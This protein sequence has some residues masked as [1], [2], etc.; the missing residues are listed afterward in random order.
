MFVY[1]GLDALQHP[2]G[3]VKA[4]EPVAGPIAERI[5]HL[6]TDTE[7]LV[8]INGAVM[9]G[10]GALLAAGKLRRLASTALILSLLPTTYAGHR[11]WE[12]SDEASRAQQRIHFLKN[13]GLLGGLILAALDTEGQPSWSWRAKGTARRAQRAASDRLSGEATRVAPAQAKRRLVGF[14]RLSEQSAK[15]VAR[16]AADASQR[17]GKTAQPIVSGGVQRAQRAGKTAQPI[18]TSGVQRAGQMWSDVAE[19]LLVR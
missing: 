16:A 7:T 5:P 1:G 2:E 4:A 19:H 17:A 10:A 13:M 12:E 3:K 15:R 6:T 8:R 11:F 9:V 14:S 18:V